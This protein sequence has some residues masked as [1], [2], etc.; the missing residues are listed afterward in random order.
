MQG[1]R[2]GSAGPV[3]PHPPP[4][5]PL[6]AAERSAASEAALADT[7]CT[8]VVVRWIAELKMWAPVAGARA[9]P[10]SPVR[11]SLSALLSSGRCGGCSELIGE[12]VWFN[13]W[14]HVAV[15]GDDRSARLPWVA[16]G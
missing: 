11:P 3:K 2:A 1:H 9:L 10:V 13:E 12:V 4:G 5:R 6:V 15:D 7:L 16:V 8:R 14:R